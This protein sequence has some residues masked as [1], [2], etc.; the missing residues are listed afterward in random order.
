LGKYWGTWDPQLKTHEAID[1][2]C[3]A[4]L[5]KHKTAAFYTYPISNEPVIT[6][7]NK[8]RGRPSKKV[9]SPNMSV[10]HFS[11]F[12]ELNR[13]D[14]EAGPLVAVVPLQVSA[15]DQKAG[16]ALAAASHPHPGR[17]TAHA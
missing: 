4:I 16:D 15:G 9:N 17:P 12:S 7:K 14:L 3:A 11:R 10:V 5:K 6:Y 8:K 1:K 2:A 13:M